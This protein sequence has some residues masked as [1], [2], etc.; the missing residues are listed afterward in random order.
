MP[1]ILDIIFAY[2]GSVSPTFQDPALNALWKSQTGMTL[3]LRCFP[4]DLWDRSTD[5]EKLTFAGLRR[6]LVLADW[7]RSLLY[8]NRIQC[9]YIHSFDPEEISPAKTNGLSRAET[10]PDH[11]FDSYVVEDKALETLFPFINLIKTIL[12]PYH[13]FDL[14]D[15]M[16]SRMA[17]AWSRIEELRV[18]FSADLHI[19]KV[20]TRT[21]LLA[22]P[23]LETTCTQTMLVDLSVGCS[24]IHSPRAVAE[25]LSNVFPNLETIHSYCL[26]AD[27]RNLTSLAE[28]RR[29]KSGNS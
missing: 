27:V 14:D 28:K 24:L 26:R 21:T 15:E 3:A 12:Q 2:A 17:R 6:P 18:I 1:E 22:I 19:A 7:E 10:P 20:R 25:F 5:S 8:W 11:E 29:Q 9:F 13:G 16:V 23:A 4:D